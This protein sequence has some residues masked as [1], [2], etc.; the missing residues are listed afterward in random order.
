MRITRQ[1]LLKIAEDTV[2]QR[3]KTQRSLLAAYLTGSV[4]R[5]GDP[6]LGGTADIDLVF[7][8][9]YE[10]PSEREI[11]RLTEDIHLDILHHTRR[12]YNQVR[13]LRV[14]PQMGPVIYSCQIL[15]DPR[16][17]LDFAQASVRAHF[18]RADNV[19]QRARTQ[20]ASARQ[21]WFT[22]QFFEGQPTREDVGRYL[23]AVSDAAGAVASIGGG[24]LSER[25]YLAE[26][27]EYTQ[28]LGKTG[29]Y[30][31][32]VGLLGAN[33][34][35][36]EQ[37]REW[38]GVWEGA[39]QAVSQQPIPPQNLHPFRLNY[40]KKAFGTFLETDRPLDV[41]WPLLMTG[42]QMM[43]SL[44][45]THPSYAFLERI[46][47]QLGLWGDKFQERIPALDAY[48][49]VIDETLE[50]WGKNQGI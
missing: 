22:F 21:I 49:D 41:V 26:F 30:A 38:V 37:L 3:V 10:A 32:V 8:H 5:E 12:E 29:L 13:E 17:F 27:F 25:R 2:A 40:Y 28:Q 39:Y 46:L 24:V 45:E 48:L 11:I 18:F 6:V 34:F 31:G 20:L 1:T 7:L 15:H 19:L 36:R 23:R 50:S 35:P 4:A 44:S 42:M 47:Q 16:H 9:E 43:E 33:M 14:H